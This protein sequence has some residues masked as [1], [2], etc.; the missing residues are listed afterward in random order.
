VDARLKKSIR[1]F[2]KFC[3]VGASGVFVN[4]VVFTSV[5]LLWLA[6]TGHIGSVADLGQSLIDLAAK[7]D[8]SAVPAAAAF[9]ANAA[10][11]VVSVFTNYY[12]N[13][14]WTFRSTGDVK[15]ELPKF[16]T[17]SVTAYVAQFAVFGLLHGPAH[18][19]PIPS[20]LVAI[21]CVMPINF[22]LNKFWSFRGA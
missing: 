21:A 6:L 4:L 15:S 11:F 14:L 5:L 1:Q 13:R 19:A 7:K 10:G 16:F 3:F 18:V 9:A 2:V 22:V 8:T 17:V 20:Q 12:L